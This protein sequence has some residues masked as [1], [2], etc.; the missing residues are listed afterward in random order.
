MKEKIRKIKDSV[1]TGVGIGLIVPIL[2][3]ILVWLLMQKVTALRNADLLLIA[4]IALNALLMNYF[5]K[6]NKENIGK[7]IIS[8]TFLWAFAFFYYKVLS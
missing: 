5:F 4:C 7:G 3:G 6:L 2:P 1:W 8:V